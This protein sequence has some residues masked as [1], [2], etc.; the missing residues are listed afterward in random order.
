MA[1]TYKLIQTINLTGTVASFAFTSIPQTFTDLVIKGSGRMGAGSDTSFSCFFNSDNGTQLNYQVILGRVQTS[2]GVR[3]A[4]RSTAL[5][6]NS[7]SYLPGA[8]DTA[9][10][11]GGLDMYITNYTSTGIKM[12][13]TRSATPDTSTNRAF[14][15]VYGNRYS[16]ASAITDITFTTGNNWVANTEFSLYGIKRA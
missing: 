16:T 1:I 15:Q 11:F 6:E 2:N 9:N 14:I 10:V 8:G 7:A 13:N 5:G 3:E 12:I 4:T